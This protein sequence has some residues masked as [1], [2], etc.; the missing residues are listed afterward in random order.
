VAQLG[1]D[2]RF[3]RLSPMARRPRNAAA[4]RRDR[5]GSSTDDTTLSIGPLVRRRAPTSEI[6]LRVPDARSRGTRRP[7]D[8]LR[9]LGLVGLRWLRGL[10][11]VGRPRPSVPRL[12]PADGTAQLTT[13]RRF[14]QATVCLLRICS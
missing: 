12:A 3:G 1:M 10:A 7:N 4:W 2:C 13:L 9:A 11:A 14:V 5:S 6:T 8:Y